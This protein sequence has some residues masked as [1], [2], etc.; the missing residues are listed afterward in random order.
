MIATL[1][2]DPKRLFLIDAIGALLSAFM[3]GI[4][5]TQLESMFGMPADVL[6]YL[7]ILALL[8]SLYSFYFYY[9]VIRS[10]KIFLNIIATFNLL[11]SGLT[12]ALVI[13]NFDQLTALGVTYFI[14]E[15]IIVMALVI[16]EYRVA[17]HQV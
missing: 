9:K 7:A 15:L 5:L 1:I 2:K 6:F 11:Y 8:F 10:Q 4:V 16:T 12:L 14:L 3:L 13:L 17:N